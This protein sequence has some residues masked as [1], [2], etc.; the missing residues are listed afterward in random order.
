VAGDDGEEVR[1]GAHG[2]FQNHEGRPRPESADDTYHHGIGN[3]V[4]AMQDERLAQNTPIADQYR[5]LF[6]YESIVQIDGT[7]PGT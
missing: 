6:K 4:E 2:G 7:R 3:D 5:Q 1:D